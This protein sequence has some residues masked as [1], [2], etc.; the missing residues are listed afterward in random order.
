LSKSREIVAD[1]HCAAAQAIERYGGHVA[2]Y[3]GDG[4]SSRDQEIQTL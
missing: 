1:Y 3:L 4:A 2:Q